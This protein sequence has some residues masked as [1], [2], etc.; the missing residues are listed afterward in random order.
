MN[1]DVRY[2]PA[3]GR[4]AFTRLYDP[5]VALTMLESRFRGLLQ[6]QVVRD[7]P[8]WVVHIGCGTGTFARTLA[9]TTDALR[10]VAVDGDAQVLDIARS[11]PGADRVD[12]ICALTEAL[13]LDDG[14]ADAITMSLVLHHLDRSGKE[15]ALAEAVRVLRPG[16]LLHVAD[17]GRPHGLVTRVAFAGLRLLDGLEP[18]RDHAAGRLPMHHR[19]CRVPGRGK[20]GTTAH[21]VGLARAPARRA[22]LNVS[23]PRTSRDGCVARVRAALSDRSSWEV[24][25]GDDELVQ[26]AAPALE[27]G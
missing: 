1:G 22:C 17:W 6:E 18:T 26:L 20:D 15:R 8:A 19:R 4:A 23:R 7:E 13:P 16:G 10:V 25:R 2:V 27:R 9:A 24:Q 5:V 3:A 12:W 11:K 14:S 21:G